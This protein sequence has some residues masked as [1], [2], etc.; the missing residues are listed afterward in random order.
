MRPYADLLFPERGWTKSVF[1]PKD[2]RGPR[3]IGAEPLEYQYI[4]QGLG[5]AVVDWTESHR[6]TA[7]HINFRDQ[8]INRD[9]ATLGSKTGEWA[10]LDLRDASDRVSLK[11]VQYLWQDLPEMLDCLMAA[12]SVGTLLPRGV[13]AIEF[14]KYAPMGS[15]LC[16]PVLALTVAAALVSAL[17]H[18]VNKPVPF[19]VYGDDVIVRTVDVEKAVQGLESAGLMV[20]TGKSC[21]KGNF[22]ESCGMDA[23]F[24]R[25][26]TPVRAKALW[27]RD[28]DDAR[29][30]EHYVELANHLGRKA[31]LFAANL[32]WQELEAVYGFIPF[33][34]PTSPFPCRHVSP[35]HEAETLNFIVKG[36][37]RRWHEEYQRPQWRVRVI[38]NARKSS[39]LG[40]WER[41]HRSLLMGGGEEFDP[42][43]VEIRHST[44]IK[45]R[46]RSV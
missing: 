17:R 40:G 10:T 6:L 13:G 36:L 7:G 11:L 41:L 5:R 37:R 30:Y 33:G 22:R 15:A 27:T 4:E 21:F 23:Y 31:W 16:F 28:L 43:F 24:G 29:C 32:L 14:A 19:F 8:Q 12:R 18:D 46:W 35:V 20:N 45:W 3:L 25:D 1:V 9:L 39:K 26:V 44:S 42:S 38:K 2:A 34:L